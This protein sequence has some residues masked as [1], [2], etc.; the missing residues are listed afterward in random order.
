[1]GDAPP[2]FNGQRRR[3]LTDPRSPLCCL[4]RTVPFLRR[5][6]DASHT[7]RAARTHVKR[8][9]KTLGQNGRPDE[10]PPLSAAQRLAACSAGSKDR[11]TNETVFRKTTTDRGVSKHKAFQPRDQAEGSAPE[12]HSLA[13]SLAKNIF[14][15]LDVD[16]FPNALAFQTKFQPSECQK[17]WNTQNFPKKRPALCCQLCLHLAAGVWQFF[18][19]KNSE[20][21]AYF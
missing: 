5:P 20:M 10:V 13:L 21:S 1:M 18:Y 14:G 16:S 7:S 3:L 9:F 12:A 2:R 11:F 6:R 15:L 8:R 4:A 17:K 19:K